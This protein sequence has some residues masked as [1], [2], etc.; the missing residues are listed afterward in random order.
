MAKSFDKL[1]HRVMSSKAH[2]RASAR[3]NELLAE[4]LLSEVRKP[5]GKGQRELARVL[6]IKQQSLSK[7]E[8]QGDMQISTLKRIIEALGGEVQI[9]ARFSKAKVRIRQFNNNQRRTP[10]VR[11]LQLV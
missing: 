9:I 6:G 3:A 5:A 10:R 2:A 11:E 7:L 4:L 1:A 8:S